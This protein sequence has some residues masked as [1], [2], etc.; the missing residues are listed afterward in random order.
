MNNIE[1]VNTGIFSYEG[2]NH[3]FDYFTDIDTIKKINFVNVVGE[4]VV[5]DK[6]YQSVIF[7]LIFDFQVISSFS[8]ALD[9]FSEIM[10]KEDNKQFD[11]YEIIEI[12]EKTDIANIIKANVREGLISELYE[13]VSKDIE[14]KTGIH[15]NVFSEAIVNFIKTL[16]NKIKSIDLESL[17][18]LAKAI[19]NSPGEL[20]AD[21][22]VKAYG[23][24]QLAKTVRENINKK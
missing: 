19:S 7:D 2:K 24:S 16:E 18:D 12:V 4:A 10:N 20:T 9:V 3:N 15:K 21:A 23:E 22:I 6:H 17:T 1:N 13:A 11:I 5:T 14:Y 8:N